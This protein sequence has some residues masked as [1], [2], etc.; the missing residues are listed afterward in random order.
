MAGRYARLQRSIWD[1]DDFA[2]LTPHAKLVYLHLFSHRKT[3][4]CG[5]LDLMPARWARVLAMPLGDVEEAVTALEA[6][7]FVL[8]DVD[9]AELVIRTYVRHDVDLT[10]AHM[11]KGVWNAW[12]QVESPR[13]RTELL[14]EFPSAVWDAPKKGQSPVPPGVSRPFEQGSDPPS[15]RA[16]QGPS[17]RALER[18]LELPRPTTYDLEHDLDHDPRAA[19]DARSN[20]PTPVD[21]P[22]PPSVPPDGG[23]AAA[24]L[25]ATVTDAAFIVAARRRITE[26]APAEARNPTRWLVGARSG[27]RSELEAI[28]THGMS[29]ADLADLVEPPAPPPAPEPAHL[30]LNQL[31]DRA[32]R[33]VD[34][35]ACPDCHDTGM[36]LDDTDTAHT[37]SHDRHFAAVAALAGEDDQ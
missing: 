35:D 3:T 15:E 25:A 8:V 12:E 20:D 7:R 32:R 11:A 28:A 9:T 36:V 13:L 17:E 34:G 10:R 37:C 29:A 18:P 30:A 6:A 24:Q 1:D 5:L 14:A 27:I 4:T 19:A 23:A 33:R 16:L 22:S 21:D 2:A 26:R 31:A